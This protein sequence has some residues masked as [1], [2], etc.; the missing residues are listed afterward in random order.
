[1]S[2]TAEKEKPPASQLCARCGEGQRG[3]TLDRSA[4]T[5][6]SP[7]PP[8][9][10]LRF[11][12]GGDATGDS[13]ADFPEAGEYTHETPQ[14]KAQESEDREVQ[15]PSKIESGGIG[16]ADPEEEIKM[17]EVEPNPIEEERGDVS[18]EEEEGKKGAEK[19][20]EEETEVGK[21]GE[22]ETEV[23]K[24]GE[25]AEAVAE[26]GED[27]SLP[28]DAKQ[29]L[30]QAPEDQRSTGVGGEIMKAAGDNL[31]SSVEE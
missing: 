26:T 27:Q 28:D 16:K 10:G 29:E 23:G 22:E 12:G 14:A 11:G 17:K 21:A 8:P 24:A 2:S 15:G 13:Q 4:S 31:A 30:E 20:G 25:G 18:K 6:R 1:M 9:E 5:P 19:E 7:P 3:P